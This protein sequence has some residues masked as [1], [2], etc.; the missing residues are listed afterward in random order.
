MQDWAPRYFQARVGRERKRRGGERRLMK[1]KIDR[2]RRVEN[3]GGLCARIAETLV[4]KR[5]IE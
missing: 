1:R 3:K 5:R 2:E 4:R